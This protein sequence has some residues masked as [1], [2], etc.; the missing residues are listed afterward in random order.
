MFIT[1]FSLSDKKR[2]MLNKL[3][4]KIVIIPILSHHIFITIAI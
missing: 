1:L 2:K 4:K 3:K